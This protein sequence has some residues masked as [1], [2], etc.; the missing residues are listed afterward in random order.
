MNIFRSFLYG[1]VSTALCLSTAAHAGGYAT[2]RFGGEHGHPAT[3]HPTAMY[4][5]PAGLTLGSGTRVY[6]EGLLAYR[7]ATFERPVE[8]IDN[9]GSGTPDDADGRAANTGRGE[10]SN[11][12]VSPFLG[13]VTDLG[14]ESLGLA[15]GV[16]A[17][18][19]GQASW[20]EN[21]QF[22]NSTMYPGAVDG[23]QRWSTIEGSQR[24]L[25]ATVAGAYRLAGPRLSIGVGL[26][27]VTQDVSLVRARNGNGTDDLVDGLGEISEG[28]T[29][30]EG[31]DMSL[32]VGAGILWEATDS[33]RVGLSYQSTPGFGERALE[34]E[35]T[36]KFGS[37]EVTVTE[38]ELL[39]TLPDTFRAGVTFRPISMLEVRLSGDYTRWSKFERH[40]LL[41]RSVPDRKCA[42][43]DDGSVDT[44]AGGAGVVVVIPR[45]WKDTYGVR[46][47]ASFWASDAL[48]VFGGVG[49]DSNAVPD[50]T[51]DAGVMD[52]NKVVSSVGARY[53]LRGGAMSL[54]ASF[55]NV[56]YASRDV[57]ARAEGE[58]PMIPSRNPDG[59][60]SYSQSVNLLTVG[61]LYAFQ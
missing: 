53:G 5:N 27:A 43:N 45:D 16:Y 24:A 48:E 20:N 26:N 36:N 3:A 6:G 23:P 12:L 50:E 2:A 37:G 42:L 33:L 40:C 9:L 1:A 44:N 13:V 11:F 57:S 41:D 51:L 8:A 18:F 28:R 47:G 7:T 49:F 29:L 21:D 35:L 17:P 22:A 56:T 58:A 55:T 59:A 34:G 54:A 46:A 52:M 61:M 30:I 31:S 25:Y 14:I 39:F 38:T 15:A 10:L 19:G 32:S 60:G 4:F